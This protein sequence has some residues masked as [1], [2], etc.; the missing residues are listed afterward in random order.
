LDL[1]VREH[2]ASL[3]FPRGRME[4][5]GLIGRE[6]NPDDAHSTLVCLLPAGR[7]D[8]RN[9]AESNMAGYQ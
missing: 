5:D 7:H 9:T 6:P 4:K 3:P 2:D 8:R 1:V